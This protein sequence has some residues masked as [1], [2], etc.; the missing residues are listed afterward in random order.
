MNLF[1]LTVEVQLMTRNLR[2]L[3]GDDIVAIVHVFTE[4][5]SPQICGNL[6]IYTWNLQLF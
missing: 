3:S 2:G 4:S 1:Q 5:K 6:L